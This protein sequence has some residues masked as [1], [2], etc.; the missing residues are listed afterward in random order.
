MSRFAELREA[1]VDHIYIVFGGLLHQ[2]INKLR[3]ST[4]LKEK[5]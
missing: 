4:N 3:V 1:A 5:S 2:A